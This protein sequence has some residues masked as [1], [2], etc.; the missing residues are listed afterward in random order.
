VGNKIA[1]IS[2]LPKIVEQQS[3]FFQGIPQTLLPPG[4]T[5]NPTSSCLILGF[6]LSTGK[7]FLRLILL[8][9]YVAG[10]CMCVQV[11]SALELE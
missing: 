10:V 3:Y 7:L 4:D 5:T 6:G 2:S 11:P 9:N 8:V 1:F